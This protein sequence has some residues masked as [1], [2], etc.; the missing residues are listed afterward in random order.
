M[1]VT[2]YDAIAEQYRQTEKVIMKMYVVV[3]TFLSI[4]GDIKDKRVV[5][6]ACGSGYF[7]RLIRKKG[8]REAVGIDIS[9]KEIGLAEAT[10]EKESLGIS[11]YI[12]DISTFNFNEIEKF[13][14]ATAAYLLHYASS[15]EE[16]LKMC[17]NI[18]D[19]LKSG[20][21]FTALN[22]N[23]TYPTQPHKKYEATAL[24]EKLPLVEGG[25]RKLDYYLQDKLLCTFYTFFWEKSTYEDALT[26]AGFKNI[27]WHPLIVSDEGMQKYGKEFWGE[28]LEI[29]YISG[30]TCTKD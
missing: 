1:K 26:K 15:K 14:V 19:S 20:G 12:S 22:S 18:Y 25:R 29:P 4:L 13:D 5:D 28:L 2:Q 9:S 11:Y 27:K 23:P 30:L 16:L 7:T 17:R 21:R 3:P 10:E 24:A 8:A 6:L